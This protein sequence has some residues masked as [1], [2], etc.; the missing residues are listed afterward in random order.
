[1]K[2]ILALLILLAGLV[3]PW[4]CS[5]NKTPTIPSGPGLGGGGNSTPTGTITPGTFTSTPTQAVGANTFTPTPTFALAVPVFQ[6]NYS[7]SAAPRGMEVDG[8]VLTASE[9][10][11]RS[12]G[13]VTEFEEY[14]GAGTASLNLYTCG[15]GPCVGNVISTGCPPPVTTPGATPAE[16]IPNG[17]TLNQVQGFVNPGGCCGAG[18][19]SAVLD[20]TGSAA[21]LYAGYI[22]YWS[23]TFPPQGNYYMPFASPDYG[24]IPF[25]N[26]QAMTDD[27]TGGTGHMYIADTGNGY[28]DELSPYEG[29]C[30]DEPLPIHRFNGSPGT[31]VG[32]TGVVFSAASVTFKSPTAVS[33]DAAG[34][35]WVGDQGYSPSY[36]MEFTSGATTILESWQAVA[37]CKV[38]GLAINSGTGNVYVSDSGNNLVEIYSPTGTLLSAFGDPGPAAHELYP[39]AP[40][41]IAFSGG[42]IYVGDTNND[43]IDI[44]E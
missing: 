8:G 34:D 24:G 43:Y 37:G 25:N 29:S 9:S 4:A 44:F 1:M 14:T 32:G 31:T 27:G 35:I 18:A 5:D 40:S 13:L 26:P 6:G 17:T 3:F 11:V 42:F 12:T 16:F 21:T 23:S 41:C 33:C 36:I 30:P 22:G 2:K 7:T 38:S 28:V 10:E 19:W 20:R 39:F 15:G